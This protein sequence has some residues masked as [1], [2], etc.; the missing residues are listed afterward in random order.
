MT[1]RN[2]F[3]PVS[4]PSIT[5]LEISY[6]NDAVRSTWI[7]SLGKYIDNFENQFSEFCESKYGIAVSNGTVAIQ[8][9]L[10]ALGIGEG[11]EVIVPDFTFIASANAVLHAGAKPV[12]ADIENDTLCIDPEDIKKKITE[13]TK[14]IMPVHV[15]GHPAEMELIAKIAEENN[16]LLIEDAAEAH[17]ARYKGRRVGSLSDAACFSFYGNK[18]MTTG[19]GGMIITNDEEL[20]I[21]CKHLRDQAMS[22]TKRY[23]HD[24]PGFNFRMTNLQAAIGCAQLER[25]EELL[26]KRKL[27]FNWYKAGLSE[28][29]GVQLNTIRE[30][31]EHAF[32]MVC[33]ECEEFDEQ[34]RSRFM[35]YL[36]EHNIDSRP[37]FYPCSMMPYF[38]KADNVNTYSKFYKGINLPTFFDLNK[39]DIDYICKIIVNYF[40]TL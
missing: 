9:A 3:I 17:G 8:L 5:E 18:N 22:P 1:V 34:S 32:W 11:D 20:A 7:S 19:E 29:D 39:E 6:V 16:L 25:S 23:W 14:A 40:N 15:Y 33:L 26:L 28:L 36:K 4:Q 10:T 35:S 24:A 12:F 2:T 38:N 27:I 37:Y 13:K 21:R 31:I 30:D